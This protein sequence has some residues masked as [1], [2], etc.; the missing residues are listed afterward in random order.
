MK[1]YQDEAWLWKSYVDEK[2]SLREIADEAGCSYQTIYRYLKLFNI[3]IRSQLESISKDKQPEKAVKKTQTLKEAFQKVAELNKLVAEVEEL[4][5]LIKALK[6]LPSEY[7]VSES[8]AERNRQIAHGKARKERYRQ[9]KE[10]LEYEKRRRG[11]G[12]WHRGD[13]RD[14][15]YE[16][17]ELTG[18]YI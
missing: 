3:P 15:L 1:F 9:M 14:E 7:S 13:I 10:D 4:E 18:D 2:M 8:E 5:E 12:D 16:I 6:G 11:G 17:L